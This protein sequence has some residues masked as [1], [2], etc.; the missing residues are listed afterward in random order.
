MLEGLIARFVT[1][2]LTERCLTKINSLPVRWDRH[3][4]R[5]DGFTLAGHRADRYFAMIL[6]KMGVLEASEE[7]LPV[8]QQLSDR[9]FRLEVLGSRRAGPRVA[10]DAAA[11]EGHI[12]VLARKGPEAAA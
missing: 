7:P 11:D 10:L 6:W 2:G 5:L 9:G 1:A 8:L 4:V 3:P 12:S